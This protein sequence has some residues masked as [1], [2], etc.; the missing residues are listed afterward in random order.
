MQ[1]EFALQAADPVLRERVV[2]CL[3][4]L[5]PA[6]LAREVS[7]LSADTRLLDAL[8]MTSTAALELLL[9]LEERLELEVSVEDL[10]QEHLATVGSLADYVAANLLDEE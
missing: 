4:E 9:R 1:P 3:C 5:L 8:G 7:G 2:E 10:G 6:V